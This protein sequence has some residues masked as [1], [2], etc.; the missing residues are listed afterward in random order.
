MDEKVSIDHA[1]HVEPVEANVESQNLG[2][3][4]LVGSKL[5]VEDLLGQ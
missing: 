5:D 3:P 1:M 2:E 4:V